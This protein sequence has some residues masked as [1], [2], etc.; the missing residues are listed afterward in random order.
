MARGQYQ[1]M[2]YTYRYALSY[3]ILLPYVLLKTPQH[4]SYSAI[5]LPI[6]ALMFF[7]DV[8]TAKTHENDILGHKMTPGQ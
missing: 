2:C 6:S 3:V 8:I 4:F 5:L 1:A 7:D